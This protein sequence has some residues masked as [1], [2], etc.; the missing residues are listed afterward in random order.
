MG[1]LGLW[2]PQAQRQRPLPAT[3]PSQ[4]RASLWEITCTQAP[5]LAGG[6]GTS[7]PGVTW[8]G[9]GRSGP[10]SRSRASGVGPGSQPGGV[11]A[12]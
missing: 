4:W 5:A 3:R 6:L 7:S 9:S 2:L 10:S 11:T 1:S 12:A 8:V